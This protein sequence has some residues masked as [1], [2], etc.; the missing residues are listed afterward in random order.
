MSLV[1]HITLSSFQANKSLF[2]LL[3]VACFA[4]KHFSRTEEQKTL[5]DSVKRICF[6][7]IFV[8]LHVQFYRVIAWTWM[9]IV[10]KQIFIF[11]ELVLAMEYLTNCS[12]KQQS[13]IHCV[14]IN[15]RVYLLI[16]LV[17]IALYNFFCNFDIPWN[18]IISDFLGRSLSTSS[19]VL[20]N[21]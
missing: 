13:L 5:V 17:R 3:K 14:I 16:S 7:S 15:I 8:L 4:V 9:N 11:H 2:L 19:F 21:K 12:L 20:L 10:P 6:E 1:S 18:I